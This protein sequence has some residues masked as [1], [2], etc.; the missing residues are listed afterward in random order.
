MFLKYFRGVVNGSLWW[1]VHLSCFST[2][3][4]GKLPRTSLANAEPLQ[5]AQ[6]TDSGVH[7]CPGA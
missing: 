3:F 5:Q 2:Y 4:H 6:Q 7:L 1:L